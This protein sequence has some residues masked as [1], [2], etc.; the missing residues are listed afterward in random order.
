MEALGG[1]KEEVDSTS[2]GKRHDL[3]SGGAGKGGGESVGFQAQGSGSAHLVLHERNKRADDSHRP[4]EEESR[5]LEAD[6]FP[7]SRGEY[8]Q[9]VSSPENR[10]DE[11][12][13]TRPEPR[14]SQIT[15]ESRG[16]VMGNLLG[17][18]RISRHSRRSGNGQG[19][20][21]GERDRLPRGSS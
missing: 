21:M 8:P 5:E 10:P 11:R 12:L 2:P 4:R 15:P 20:E 18:V 7:P 3:L 1:H 14:E 13:L 6:A 19:R 16:Q 9:S 17:K